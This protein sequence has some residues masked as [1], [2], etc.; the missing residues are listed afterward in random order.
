MKTTALWLA[1]CAGIVACGSSTPSATC[2]SACQKILSCSANGGY[3]YGFGY[4]GTAY[5]ASFG[6]GI[7]GYAPA[8]TL[9]EC[10]SGC[11]ALPAADQSRIISCISTNSTCSAELSCA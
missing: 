11:E 8:L 9:S 3:G 7:Y 1:L 5:P 2:Q 4:S 10:V 6:Y